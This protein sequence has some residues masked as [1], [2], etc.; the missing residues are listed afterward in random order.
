MKAK[1]ETYIDGNLEPIIVEGVYIIRSNEGAWVAV[2]DGKGH[3]RRVKYNRF[4]EAK[5]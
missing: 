2:T 4:M 1:I 5:I 3:H